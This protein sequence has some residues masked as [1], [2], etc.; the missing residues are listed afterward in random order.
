MKTV[1]APL[2]WPPGT[3]SHPD[4]KYVPAVA[5]DIRKTFARARREQAGA[6][7]R[8]ASR[9]PEVQLLL[10]MPQGGA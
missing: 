9:K 3:S 8:P 1:K 4:F 6:A 2:H 10:P 7:A 5:T